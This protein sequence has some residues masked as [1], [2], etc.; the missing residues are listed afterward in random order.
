M[1]EADADFAPDVFDNTYLNMGLD[2]QRNGDGPDFAK[3]KNRLRDTDGL[4]IGRSHNN[5]SLDTIMYD[6][7]YKY[8]HKASLAA[9]V[10]VD[11][12][13]AQ[14]DGEGNRHVLFQDIFDHRYNGTEVKEQ[15][16]LI[17]THS[18]MK[19]RRE[20]TKGFE[21]LAQSKYGSTKWVTLKDM[22]NSYPVQMAEYVVQRRI[23]GDPAFS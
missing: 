6:V 10:I 19:R 12:M 21:F 23:T 2:I 1:P 7:E 17:T 14:V 9:N 8:R 4:P 16:A 20:T 15:G 5:P 22:K 11:N 18:E 13:F 3:V